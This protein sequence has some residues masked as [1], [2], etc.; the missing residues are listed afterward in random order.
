[1][2][3]VNKFMILNLFLIYKARRYSEESKDKKMVFSKP[4][5]HIG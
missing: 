4:E 2:N 3:L 1:M 5:G